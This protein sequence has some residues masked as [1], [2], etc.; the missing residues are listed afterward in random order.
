MAK[1]RKTLKKRGSCNG[2]AWRCQKSA[3]FALLGRR[4]RRAILMRAEC[5]G[6]GKRRRCKVEVIRGMRVVQHATLPTMAKAK[7]WACDTAKE[8]R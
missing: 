5:F 8:W 6:K 1:R 2:A 4:Y 7:E 3:C